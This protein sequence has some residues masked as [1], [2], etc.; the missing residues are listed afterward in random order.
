MAGSINGTTK[1]SSSMFVGETRER[2]TQKGNDSPRLTD[3]TFHVRNLGNC[4]GGQTL[5]YVDI[6]YIVKDI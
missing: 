5:F 4:Y 1:E 2:G 3:R 6:S